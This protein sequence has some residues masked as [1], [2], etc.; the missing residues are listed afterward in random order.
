MA[1]CL[2]GAELGYCSYAV[3]KE[4]VARRSASRHAAS[5][6]T[7][8]TRLRA[9]EP[10]ASP[11]KRTYLSAEQV[12]ERFHN[13]ERM[14]YRLSSAETFDLVRD[15]RLHAEKVYQFHATSRKLSVHATSGRVWHG[16]GS[17]NR[18]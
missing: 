6:V 12:A 9:N 5:K 11:V 17:P 3:C 7:R 13:P 16:S 1:T 2:H 18:Y 14:D 8:A 10:P 15:S 4:S